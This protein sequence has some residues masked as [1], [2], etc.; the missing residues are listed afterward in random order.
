MATDE[1][2]ETVMDWLNGLAADSYDE[3]IIKLVRLDTCLNHNV[4]YVENKHMLYLVV[5]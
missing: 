3:G 4:N 1:V 5:T 2:K